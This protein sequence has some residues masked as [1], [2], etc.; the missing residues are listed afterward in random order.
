[1]NGREVVSRRDIYLCSE[2]K[3]SNNLDFRPIDSIIA[4]FLS[5]DF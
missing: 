2:N 3:N 4:T 5:L 1:M